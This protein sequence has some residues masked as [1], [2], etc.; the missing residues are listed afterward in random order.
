[1]RLVKFPHATVVEPISV[2]LAS[3]PGV[4][5]ARID[6]GA[7]AGTLQRLP[8]SRHW[9]INRVASRSRLDDAAQAV[10]IS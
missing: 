8:G 1:M 10:E 3:L 9:Q 2:G 4:H 7:R 5:V 6:H